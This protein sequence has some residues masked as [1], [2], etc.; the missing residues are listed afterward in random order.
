MIKN[1]S[2]KFEGAYLYVSNGP[3]DSSSDITYTGDQIGVVC[4][5]F[6]LDQSTLSLETVVNLV[7]IDMEMIRFMRY[8]DGYCRDSLEVE[9][10]FISF[11]LVQTN[12]YSLEA[13]L[14]YYHLCLKMIT[15]LM[16]LLK[17]PPFL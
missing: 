9:Q 8:S 6:I 14:I 11:R 4:G 15:N 2:S 16:K 1:A 17:S 3:S 12:D 10:N 7:D 13:I 5:E